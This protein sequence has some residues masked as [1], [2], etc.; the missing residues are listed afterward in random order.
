MSFG[1]LNFLLLVEAVLLA[2]GLLGMRAA[3]VAFIGRPDALRD[4]LAL[5]LTY[6]ALEGTEEILKRLFRES[7]AATETL[8]H[9]LGQTLRNAGYGPLTGLLLAAASALGEEVFFRG[10]LQSL[11]LLWLPAP[12]AVPI[13][14]FTFAL[15]HPTPN[16]KAWAYPLFVG[17]AGLIFGI[18]YLLTGSLVPGILAHFVYNAKGFEEVLQG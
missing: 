15:F 5:A 17:F 9:E 18:S 10:F 7:F 1:I 11:L 3:G 13:V 8:M 4:A 16:R 12:V 2:S 6:L 14:A